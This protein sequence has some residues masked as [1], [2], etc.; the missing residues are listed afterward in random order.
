MSRNGRSTFTPEV[1]AAITARVEL[2]ASYVD[3]ARAAGVKPATAKTWLARGRREDTGDYHDFATGI[4]QA[5]EQASSGQP[6]D[7]AELKRRV[8]AM[9]EAGSVEAAKLYHRMLNTG[10]AD[11]EADPWAELGIERARQ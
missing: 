4:E 6:G 7:A 5:R 3:A 9:V 10:E 2:G 1:R 8:W 11:G